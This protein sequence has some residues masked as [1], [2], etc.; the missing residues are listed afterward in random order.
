MKEFVCLCVCVCVCVCVFVSK[1][2]QTSPICLFKMGDP[3]FVKFCTTTR[4]RDKMICSERFLNI[5]NRFVFIGGQI[6]HYC[7]GLANRF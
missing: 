3:I 6:F 5:F 1:K 4:L 2:T 7:I